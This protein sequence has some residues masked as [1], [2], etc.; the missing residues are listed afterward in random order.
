MEKLEIAKFIL[1]CLTLIVSILAIC[2]SISANSK[3]KENADENTR[4]ANGT[5][6]LQ[7]RN[8]ISDS[9]RH[10]T[11]CIHELVALKKNNENQELTENVQA[12]YESAKQDYLNSYEEACSKY[13]DNKVDKTR[14][15]KTYS[16]EIRNIVEKEPFKF[17]F[18]SFSSTYTAIKKVYEEWNNL[19][20]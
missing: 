11:S 19:E 17:V 7:I 10:L 4:I 5:I 18:D 9:R 3:S 16:I 2:I 15:K 20:K 6:E 1:S 12:I 13:L 8:M 14:F